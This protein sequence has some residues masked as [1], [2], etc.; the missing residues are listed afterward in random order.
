MFI[1]DI[2]NDLSTGKDVSK[3]TAHNQETWKMGKGCSSISQD[4]RLGTWNTEALASLI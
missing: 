4:G 3:E 1:E 2:P